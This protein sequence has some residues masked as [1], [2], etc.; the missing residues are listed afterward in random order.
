MNMK[1]LL[2]ISSLT[3]LAC[4]AVVVAGCSDS[5]EV[6]RVATEAAD[7]QAKQNEEMA[8][9]TGQVAEGSRKLV[10][11]DAAARKEIVG[12]HRDLQAE[13][14]T[15]GEQWNALEGERQSIAQDR[16]TE[17]MLVPVAQAIG[18]LLLAVVVI[19]FCWSL[20]FGLRKTDGS[21]S[22]INELLLQEFAA[23]QPRLLPAGGARPLLVADKNDPRLPSAPADEEGSD[24]PHKK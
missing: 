3:I 1:A 24:T 22:D 4:L 2:V 16:R 8:R 19:G 13:R 11:A 17:S 7:R 23:E 9:V 6:A 12:V 5:A 14:K 18:G 20:L 21:D 15:L 10:E